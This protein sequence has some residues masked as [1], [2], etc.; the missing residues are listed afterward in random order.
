MTPLRFRGDQVIEKR[1]I[2]NFTEN[3]QKNEQC[4]YNDLNE[5]APDSFADSH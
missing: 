3:D 2:C 5:K 4:T 1:S